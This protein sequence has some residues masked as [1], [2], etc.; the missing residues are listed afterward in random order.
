MLFGLSQALQCWLAL[1]HTGRKLEQWDNIDRGIV[2][3]RVWQRIEQMQIGEIDL[4]AV[5]DSRRPQGCTGLTRPL[6][7]DQSDLF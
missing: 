6:V 7:L 1:D 5:L 4:G 2:L 3:L